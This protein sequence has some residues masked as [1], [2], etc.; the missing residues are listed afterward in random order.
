MRYRP[1]GGEPED[2]RL[3]RFIT[4]DLSFLD[5]HP[6][7]A[8]S[9]PST[10]VPVW[11]GV[12]WYSDFDNPVKK[13][14]AYYIGLNPKQL[15]RIRGGHSTALECGDFLDAQGNIVKRVQDLPQWWDFYNQGA[16]G[17]CVGFA[18]SR[19][20]SLLNRKLYFARWLWDRAKETDEWAETNPGDDNGTSVHAASIYVMKHGHVVWNKKYAPMDD[21]PSDSYPRSGLQPTLGEGITAVKWARSGQDVLDALQSPAANK[22]GLV[23]LLNSW[24]RDYPH[25]VHVPI[26]TIDRLI[27]EDGEFAIITDRA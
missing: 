21:D 2:P 22:S 13:G 16:E 9:V 26:E 4:D 1:V 17:A 8:A 10:P 7:T 19:V 20:L 6:L 18:G 3:G 27:Q 12:N 11:I 23:R 15:G 25:R 5:K 14:N 24:G